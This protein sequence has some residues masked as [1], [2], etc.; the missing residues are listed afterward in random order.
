MARWDRLQQAGIA[1]SLA[2]PYNGPPHSTED[3][4]QTL[5]SSNCELCTT[6]NGTS[7]SSWDSSTAIRVR[8]Q[9]HPGI[10][11]VGCCALVLVSWSVRQQ[12]GLQIE[13]VHH[14]KVLTKSFPQQTNMTTGLPTA[15]KAVMEI[16]HSFASGRQGKVSQGACQHQSG[17]LMLMPKLHLL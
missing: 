12:H 5:Y 3:G 6:A 10:P 15:F 11:D 14:H 9:L 7:A 8:A 1:K 2:N 17:L 13:R 4:I 16:A